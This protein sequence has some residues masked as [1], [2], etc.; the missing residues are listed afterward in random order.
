MVNN[1]Q[2]WDQFSS[3]IDSLIDQQHR[4]MEQTDNVIILHRSQGAI[5]Q[6]RRLKFL[7]DEVQKTK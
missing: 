3:Y 7:R 4:I 5:F 2:Q 6:L 1:T